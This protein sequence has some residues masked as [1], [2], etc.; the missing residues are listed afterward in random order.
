MQID[1]LLIRNIAHADPCGWNI[2]KNSWSMNEDSTLIQSYTISEAKDRESRGRGVM[3]GALLKLLVKDKLPHSRYVSTYEHERMAAE[4]KPLRRKI[5]AENYRKNG[6]WNPRGEK[7]YSG[8]APTSTKGQQ[9]KPQRK[10]K[11]DDNRWEIDW[12]T[13]YSPSI[14]TI[15]NLYRIETVN[16]HSILCKFSGTTC[17]LFYLQHLY[18]FGAN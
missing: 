1:T 12:H 18:K 5:T 7:D 8:W 9:L 14:S 16:Y 17:K 6:S 13:T 2:E 15:S 3:P 4:L 10:E 11:W